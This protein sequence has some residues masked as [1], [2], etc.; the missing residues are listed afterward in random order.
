MKI[1]VN[2]PQ[3]QQ[4]LIEVGE[5][6]GYFDE[7]RVIW[8]ERVDGIIPPVTLGAMVRV[9]GALS[10]DNTMLE[11]TVASDLSKAKVNQIN[12]LKE[13]Y[14]TAIQQPVSYTS[15]GGVT[16]I[17]QADSGSVYN[18]QNVLLGL[19]GLGVVPSGFYWVSQDDTHVP[20]TYADLQGLAEAMF[21][22]GLMAFQ[23]LQTQKNAV[24]AATT[25]SSVQSIIW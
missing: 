20:F 5:G 10:I 6:G 4:E 25:V 13:S 7:S 23:H 19:S 15:A 1:L 8:D 2:N 22:Q 9:N 11:T 12:S 24:N 3:G 16:K 14:N 21:T 18:L 17:F